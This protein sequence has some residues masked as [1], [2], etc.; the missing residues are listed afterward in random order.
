MAVP[1]TP[2]GPSPSDGS[3]TIA[4]TTD[5]LWADAVG[6]DTYD[7]Y[8]GTSVSP[9]LVSATQPGRLYNPP[10]DLSPST[11]YYW[12]IVATN[13][14]GSTTG[15][16]W[17]FTTDVATSSPPLTPS[18]PSPGNGQMTVAL[19][20]T[21]TWYDD[22]LASSYSVAF[23]TSAT[24]SIVSTGLTAASYTPGTLTAFTAYYWQITAIGP[25]GTTV[26]PIWSFTTGPNDPP[27]G[28]PTV[29]S[30]PTPAD[31]QN[32][33][34]TTPTLTWDGDD[35]I[36]YDVYFGT[37]SPPPSVATNLTVRSYA[38]GTLSDRTTY[39][40]RVVAHRGEYITTSD[41]DYLISS[42]GSYLTT[43]D[44]ATAESPIWRFLV[45]TDVIPSHSKQWSLQL[46]SV[47]VTP[48]ERS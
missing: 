10:T 34:S 23:G 30:N 44:T 13:G 32:F 37:V 24:P 47:K 29:P 33:V 19:A 14:D 41:G 42:D 17:S 8:F 28:G 18:N 6:A 5:L 46:F 26:G 7:V 45:A 3:D 25:G 40:W 21:L 38:P 43:S 48:Q 12:K 11:I 35:G 31:R 27:S 1:P 36:F 9:P 16:V 15:P 2:S 22:A 39:Y 20:P 4:M